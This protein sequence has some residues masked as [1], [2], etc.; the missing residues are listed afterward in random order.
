MTVTLNDH[1]SVVATALAAIPSAM[2]ATI[3]LAIIELGARATELTIPIPVIPIHVAVATNP[4]A[5][6]LCACYGRSHDRDRGER[7]KSIS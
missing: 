5:E 4:N 7:S 6:L 2:T 1:H 3:V